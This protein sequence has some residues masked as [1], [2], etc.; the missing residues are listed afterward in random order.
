MNEKVTGYRGNSL[1]GFKRF[2]QSAQGCPPSSDFGETS[3]RGKPAHNSGHKFINPE[4]RVA[5]DVSP[6][7]L[8]PHPR[9]MSRLAPAATTC[10]QNPNNPCG[11]P[12]W[13]MGKTP[14]IAR[15]AFR[16]T[17]KA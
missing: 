14:Y 8:L 4:S 1:V 5:A 12:P 11:R 17:V 15:K 10:R 6:L 2:H 16:V 7:H 3:W 13:R 9:I